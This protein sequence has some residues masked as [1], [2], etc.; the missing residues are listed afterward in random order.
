MR[1]SGLKSL[2]HQHLVLLV[3][4]L[5]ATLQARAQANTYWTGPTVSFSHE[6]DTTTVDM[7]T[8]NH[9]G[10]DATNNVWLTR[11]TTQPLYN[12]AAESAWDPAVSPA[13]TLWVVASGDLTNAASLTYDTF[14]N[15]VG[16][17]GNSPKYKVGTTFFVKIFSDNI[18]LALT[19]TS[20]GS[21]D[22]GSFSYNR[23]TPAVITP[24]PAPTVTI[25]N[26]APA[27]VF[28]TP[29]NLKL[30]ADATVSA[31]TVTNVAFFANGTPAGAVQTAPFTLTTSSLV[32]GSYALT[33]VATA[34]G[35]SATSTVVNVSVVNPVAVKL[36]SAEV[37]TGQFSFSYTANTGLSYVIQSSPN[38]LNWVSL[39]TNRAA[40]SSVSYTNSASS[41]GAVFYR[42]GRMPNP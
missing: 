8:S 22:G 6:A 26:P 18:Y 33:A 21:D 17:P 40:A 12:A 35:I 9:T 13:N 2:T 11:G 1:T 27:A 41:T 42:I 29:A 24:P 20:W 16:Q 38:L 15:V 31:G 7:L 37:R 34:A 39:A 4:F 19:L 10:A 28:A 23:S 14:A 30:G 5:G 32:A 25:T 3:I 36:S